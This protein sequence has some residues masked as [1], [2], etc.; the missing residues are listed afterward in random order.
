MA[1]LTVTATSIG[2]YSAKVT[3]MTVVGLDNYHVLHGLGATPNEVYITLRSS[4]ASI[5][6]SV[7]L[8]SYDATIAWFSSNSYSTAMAG[9][10][11]IFI[12][13]THSLIL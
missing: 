5:P 6:M 7:V 3:G 10:V 9:T 4:S 2:A 8:G 12:R 1:T 11:D 13:R